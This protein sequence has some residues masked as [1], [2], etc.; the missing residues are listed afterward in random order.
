MVNSKK[1]SKSLIALVVMALLLVASIVMAVTGAWFTD[2]DEGKSVDLTFGKITMSVTGGDTFGTVGHDTDNTDDAYLTGVEIMPGDTIK[3]ALTVA[4]AAD[5]EDFYYVVV[6]NAQI[7][8]VGEDDFSALNGFTS[9][10]A[11]TVYNTLNN[12]FAGSAD[13]TLTGEN[14]GNEYEGATIKVSYSVEAVQM[15]NLTEAEALA[16]LNA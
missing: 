5:S 13:I 7:K 16:I 8:K 1:S 12:P 11:D 9:S 2:A 15:A 6:V 10:T 4:K 3:A 14:Y